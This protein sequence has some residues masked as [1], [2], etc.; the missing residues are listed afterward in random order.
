MKQVDKNHYDFQRYSHEGRWASY[1]F[2][3]KEV[4]A[5][6]PRN[7]L[8]IGCGDK[9]FS[10]F[11]KNNTKVSYTSVDV[12]EDLGPDIV[13]SASDLPCAD[14]S[15]DVV[16]AFEVLE[17]IPF[18]KFEKCL[19][20]MGR[21]S[22]KYVC[23]SL[24]HFGPSV[25]FLLKIPFIKRIRV[26]FKIPYY[27]VHTFNGEH[28]WEIGKRGYSV[29]KIKSILKKFF[30]VKKEFVPFANQYHHF[31]ILEKKEQMYL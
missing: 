11:I 1:F 15:F 3:L 13:A 26:A 4:L 7:I 28:Y 30:L 25:E 27:P 2:Q 17:H 10:N 18:E 8:E 5:L 14:S 16:C 9:V 31:Y 24:P 21:V 19:L 20:E 22:N 23:I 29:N 6:K 12:A